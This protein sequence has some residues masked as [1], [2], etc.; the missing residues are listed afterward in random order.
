M[1]T[2]RTQA[3]GIGTAAL[4]A[5]STPTLAQKPVTPGPVGNAV[6]QY[7]TDRLKGELQLTPEQLP[8][9]HEIN[10]KTATALAKLLDRYDADTTVA[11]D[12]AFVRGTL[13]VLRANQVA[14]KKVLTPIQWTK[15]QQHKAER[16]ALHQTEVMY[17]DLDLSTAQ[18][19]D[20]QRINLAASHK[21]VAALD[22]PAG[23]PERSRKQL[24]EAAKPALT[25]RDTALQKV[26]TVA[27]WKKVQTNRRALHDLLVQDAGGSVFA[28]A[29]KTKP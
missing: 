3:I 8:K 10:V 22:Q 9:V 23:A 16:L 26:L 1:T 19:L 13:D 27:Q 25:E 6:A 14:L 28:M 18:V 7:T 12:A 15:H 20:V 24:L 29:P 2:R 17:E 5:W 11:G 21:L 4:L